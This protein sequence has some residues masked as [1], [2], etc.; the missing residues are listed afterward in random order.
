MNYKA[1][2]LQLHEIQS[3][4][5][6]SLI[7]DRIKISYSLMLDFYGMKL[8]NDQTGLLVRSNGFRDRYRHLSSKSPLNVEAGI[9]IADQGASHNFLRISRILKCLS[10]M[11]LEKLNAGFLLHVLNEQS[12]CG[13]LNS[14]SLRNSMDRWWVNCIRDEHERKWIKDLLAK[15]RDKSISF[16]RGQYESVLENRTISGKLSLPGHP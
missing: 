11:G 12:E 3:M 1:Q 14:P 4:V 6:E 16:D 2:P 15:V 10:E 7:I 9:D 8:Q 13:R 5:K